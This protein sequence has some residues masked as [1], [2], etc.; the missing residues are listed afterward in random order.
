MTLR[1]P[2]K[3]FFEYSENILVLFFFIGLIIIGYILHQDYGISLDEESTRFHGL[4]SLNYICEL[5]FT[6]KKFEFQINNSIPKLHEYE[7]REYG[8]FF[9]ILLIAIIE[10]ILEIKNFSEIFYNRHFANH[11]LFIISIICFYFLCLDIFKNKLYSFLGATILYTSPR[12]F[13]QS[14]Y[15]DKDLVFLSFFIFLIFFS[16]KFIKKPVYYNAF[17]LAC[18]SAIANNIRIIGIYVVILVTFFLIIQILMKNKLDLKKI[19]SLLI[20]LF[21][22]FIFLYILWPFLWEAPFDNI[23]YALKNFSKYPWGV[24]VFYLGEF[25]KSEFLPWHYFFIYF[26]ATTPLLLSIIIILG[27]YQILLRFIKRFINIDKNNSYKDIWRSEKEKIFLFIFITIIT[28]LFLIYFLDSRLFN[29]WRHLFFLYPCLILIG[30][31]FIDR[32]ALIYPKRKMVHIFTFILG[33]I[34]INNLY[35]LIKLHPYQYIYFNSIFEKKAN[36]LFEIDYW[37]VSNKNFLE[38]I[39]KNNLEKDKIIIGVAS[40]TDLYLSRKMLPANLKNKIIIAGQEYQNV[41]FIF[42]NNIFEINPKFNDKYSIPKTFEKYL[43]LKR[44]NILINEF[45]KKR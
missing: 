20:L 18:F 12:I 2:N 45:Y 11:L 8:V 26:F 30:I 1:N 19:N 25:Y 31:Y 44:G 22:N 29:G 23:I 28:P 34:C 14:F 4:V 41:D 35:N 6:N 15:N 24:N 42:N 37:G 10:I 9:E 5:L 38:K 21:F 33:I 43:S 40:F 7:Y 13:A 27:M 16:I 39:A 3:S 17:L 32:M 36:K